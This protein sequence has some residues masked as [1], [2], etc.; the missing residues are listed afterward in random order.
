MILTPAQD[1][2]SSATYDVCIAGSGPAGITLA[3]ELANSGFK[4]C[5]LEGG[6]KEPDPRQEDT[7]GFRS[8]GAWNY[9]GTGRT[10]ALGGSSNCWGGLCSRLDPIDFEPRPWVENSGWPISYGNIEPFYAKAASILDLREW[11]PHEKPA[12]FPENL[13]F[14]GADFAPK[15]FHVSPPTR[16]QK[17][18]GRELMQLRNLH[19]FLG[20]SVVDIRLT[21]DHRSVQE[22]TV[23]LPSRKRAAVKARQF[24][25]ACGGI[26]NARILL[27]ANTQREK[28]LGNGH[29]NVGRYFMDHLYFN[30]A[31]HLFLAGTSRL[32][33][34][35]MLMPYGF[36]RGGYW[37]LQLTPERQRELSLTNMAARF[38]V[39]ESSTEPTPW[40]DNFARSG[41]AVYFSLIGEMRPLR[42]NQLRLS[43][44]RDYLGLR[45]TELDLE[46]P[47]A[48]KDAYERLLLDL[49]RFFGRTGLGRIKAKQLWGAL[50]SGS[51]HMGSTRM[52]TDPSTSVVNGDLRLHDVENLYCAGSSVFPTGGCANPT[53][54]IVAL[55]LRLAGT[56]KGQLKNA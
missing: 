38:D 3:L 46:I 19:L 26:E 53:L 44:E 39:E 48:D 6:G 8:V 17:K 37:N 14:R 1:G 34:G 21:A 33:A 42:R 28:G 49:V 31:A 10:R 9:P 22:V 25:L 45:R 15:R 24:V 12:E 23:S 27:S 54:S 47:A 41:H 30:G 7:Y 40:G 18:F 16:F 36:L 50:S 4:V 13:G 35:L 32:P 11:G 56:L 5:V 43:A 55:A 2:F 29:D 52:G 20:T 51:H